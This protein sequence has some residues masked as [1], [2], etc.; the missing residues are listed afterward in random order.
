MPDIDPAALTRLDTFSQPLAPPALPSKLNGINGLSSLKTPKAVNTVQRVDLEPLYT[1]LKGA[2]GDHWSEYKEAISLFVLGMFTSRLMCDLLIKGTTFFFSLTSHATPGQLNQNELCLR[3]DY[4]LTVDPSIEHL[5]NQLVAA[6][7]A[8]VPRDAPDAG[9]APWVSTNDKPT[10]L[11]KPISGDAAEQRLKTEVMQLPARDR[12][13][14]KELPDVSSRHFTRNE[15]CF[16]I[17][18]GYFVSRCSD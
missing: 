17:F 13:R 5:H 14:L 7:F 18:S 11:S 10:L 3:T 2:I 9:V 15:Y 4:F 12:R 16:T 1:S 8:N 6:I